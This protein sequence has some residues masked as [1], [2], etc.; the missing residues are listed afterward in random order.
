MDDTFPLS[1][2]LLLASLEWTALAV[3]TAVALRGLW[4]RVDA[5]LSPLAR[6]ALPAG[7]ALL[8]L[9]GGVAFGLRAGGAEPSVTP[10]TV[11]EAQVVNRCLAGGCHTGGIGSSVAGVLHGSAWNHLH[12]LVAWLGLSEAAFHVALHGLFALALLLIALAG[13]AT[14]GPI[15]GAVAAALTAVLTSHLNIVLGM[16]YNHRGVTF[17]GALV[18]ALLTVTATTGRAVPLVLAAVVAAV[19]TN[20][21]L[22][23]GTLGV[24]V[25]L[26]A[27]VAPGS[28]ARRVGL[29]ALAG[30]VFAATLFA[31]SPAAWISNARLLLSSA[32]LASAP[33]QSS[34]VASPLWPF[35]A[36]LAATLALGVF[37]RRLRVPVL[38]GLAVIVP[39]FVFYE[40]A[41]RSGPMV[42][43]DKYLVE[44]AP[45]L[46]LVLGALA[47][48][49][50]GWLRGLAG[51]LARRGLTLPVASLLAAA[52]M[53]TTPV[54]RSDLGIDGLP[55]Y[56]VPDAQA[57]ERHLRVERGWS[58]QR[59]M[60][61]FRASSEVATASLLEYFAQLAPE[62]WRAAQAAPSV[63][64][65]DGPDV[66]ALTVDAARLEAP[67]PENW[68][69]LRQAEG[70]ALLV[71]EGRS[72][73]DWTRFR[74]CSATDPA[75][76]TCVETGFA[77]GG[78]VDAE[79]PPRLPGM[80]YVSDA[81]SG[82]TRV[83]VHLPVRLDAAPARRV[84]LA[85]HL[86]WRC[87]ATLVGVE[88]GASQ[89]SADGRRAVLTAEGPQPQTGTVTAEW[90][91][92]TDACPW[93]VN[94]LVPWL[95][96]VD[97]TTAQRL[98]ALLPE[99]DLGAP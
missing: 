65:G 12:V 74:F 54:R 15:A 29:A 97:P 37:V 24:A 40:V 90:R 69:V 31:T 16:L 2:A 5:P 52:V 80:P 3:A 26:V 30:L 62:A 64:G 8:I 83:R 57:L 92:G 41:S 71:I 91:L 55:L 60:A 4:P 25:G 22:L 59:I 63:P 66:I 58:P 1:I 70:R 73:L 28:A 7:A 6:L 79:F 61:G 35:V 87:G 43:D 99:V 77:F 50:L 13:W 89:L 20:M 21:H 36:A 14:A 82:R 39:K 93:V 48:A 98:P 10:D 86:R 85:P 68:R 42:A 96:E 18:T 34:G 27:L 78:K 84:L 33:A 9:A 88:G 75:P 19:G 46:A 23:C 49:A 67:L 76:E 17:A 32:G 95:L 11:C 53:V 81:Q 45:A 72:W 44:A 56:S 51:P 47:A 38:V 94:G